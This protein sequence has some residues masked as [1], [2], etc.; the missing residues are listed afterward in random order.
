MKKLINKKTV[1]LLTHDELAVIKGGEERDYIIVII[2]GK[3]TKIY[4]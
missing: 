1:K 3:P 4:I 2:D